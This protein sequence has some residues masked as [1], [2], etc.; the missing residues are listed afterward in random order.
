MLANEPPQFFGGIPPNQYRRLSLSYSILSCS[1]QS[2]PSERQNDSKHRD[3]SRAEKKPT[4]KAK[5]EGAV[6]LAER[7]ILAALRDMRFFHVGQ[8]ANLLKDD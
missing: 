6:L 5:V 3:H 1:N 2:I 8:S 4:D 7:Q